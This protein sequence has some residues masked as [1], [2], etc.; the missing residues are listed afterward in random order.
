M[1]EGKGKPLQPTK[2]FLPGA[3][4]Q[5]K[6]AATNVIQQRKPPASERLHNAQERA[7]RVVN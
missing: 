7:K 4:P 6:E 1:P 2:C 3:M 5:H